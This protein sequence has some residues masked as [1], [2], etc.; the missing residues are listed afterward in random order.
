FG[1][2]DGDDDG[3]FG[4]EAVGVTGWRWWRHG[5]GWR[6][7]ARAHGDRVSGKTKKLSGISFHIKLL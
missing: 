7:E 4:G 5:S 6:V 3:G 1:Y 2:G